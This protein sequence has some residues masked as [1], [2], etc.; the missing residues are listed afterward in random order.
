MGH[1]SSPG[2]SQSLA[3]ADPRYR[4][5]SLPSSPMCPFLIAKGQ[6]SQT[7]TLVTNKQASALTVDN[8]SKYRIKSIQMLM[9]AIRNKKLAAI[10]IGARISHT[11]HPPTDKQKRQQMVSLF[12]LLLLPT[13]CYGVMH[14]SHLQTVFPKS[15][16]L[17]SHLCRRLPES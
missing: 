12:P 15:I 11:H 13:S 14:Q 16:L 3:T 4:L 17:R 6:I 7:N 1:E 9:L 10:S 2:E 8:M 5:V